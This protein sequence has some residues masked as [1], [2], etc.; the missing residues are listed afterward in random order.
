[1]SNLLDISSVINLEEYK[2]SNLGIRIEYLREKVD[3]NK[4]DFCEAIGIS[5]QTLKNIEDGVSPSFD[6]LIRI[7]DYFDTSVDY[8]LGRTGIET[9]RYKKIDALHLS[10]GSRYVLESNETYGR[11]ISLLLENEDF[12]KTLRQIDLYFNNE[13]LE[14]ANINNKLVDTAKKSID[15][16]YKT[17]ETLLDEQISDAL[18]NMLFDYDKEKIDRFAN[19]LASILSSIRL[20]YMVDSDDIEKAHRLAHSINDICD[21]L[22]SKAEMSKKM[23]IETFIKT[24]MHHIKKNKV[25]GSNDNAYE[26][27]EQA[28]LLAIKDASKPMTSK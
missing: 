8:L 25:L 1:M 17:T 21:D 2:I 20:E 3:I 10:E 16:H 18:D 27:F 23:T 11:I 24:Y 9:T 13:G 26:H 5:R 6:T 7:A 15:G 14:L 4:K 19:E 22:Y 12:R 28:F